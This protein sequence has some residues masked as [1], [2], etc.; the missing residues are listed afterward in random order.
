MHTTNARACPTHVF[1]F[2][3]A[4]TAIFFPWLLKLP[5]ALHGRRFAG[6]LLVRGE[7][8]VQSLM[9][10]HTT[11]ENVASLM[12][13]AARSS[14]CLGK[15][16]TALADVR[17]ALIEAAGDRILCHDDPT[18]PSFVD[19]A[20]SRR[21]TG[22]SSLSSNASVDEIRGRFDRPGSII[23]QPFDFH[24]GEPLTVFSFSAPNADPGKEVHSRCIT[25]FPSQTH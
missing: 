23:C 14:A 3:V 24:R 10:Q 12:F 22:A 17:Q 1:T 8:T 18:A 13:G 15:A 7:H 11:E 25:A 19:L 6:F 21:R 2:R 9:F 4:A 5:H 16:C 20:R